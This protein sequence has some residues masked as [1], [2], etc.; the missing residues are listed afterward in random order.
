M[1]FLIT[2]LSML[3]MGLSIC[4]QNCIDL[5]F[6]DGSHKKI[7]VKK[8]EITFEE[9]DRTVSGSVA[10]HDYV[11]L[12]LS[13]KWATCNMGAK[14]PQDKGDYYMYGDTTPA[15]ARENISDFEVPFFGMN[16]VLP[17][18]YDAA[19]VNWGEEWRIP[20]VEEFKELYDG[21]TWSRIMD[22]KT[23]IFVG[24]SR[25]TKNVIYLPA[26]GDY[27]TYGSSVDNDNKEATYRTSN[28]YDPQ[29]S[30]CLELTKWYN[31]VFETRNWD[32][33]WG[34]SVRP[35]TK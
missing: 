26:A 2:S 22:G 34:I 1:K 32:I 8:A 12:G 31:S 7:S 16:G 21:C 20:T 35:V 6:A 10:S 29:R 15:N 30:V 3:S 17:S 33:R 5:E 14:N 18:K 13:V 9:F 11:D 23:V 4:A 28:Q 27:N 25:K 24:T 19:T